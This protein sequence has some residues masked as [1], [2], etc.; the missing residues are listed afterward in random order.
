MFRSDPI[1]STGNTDQFTNGGGPTFLDN[2][3]FGSGDAFTNAAA[4]GTYQGQ[5]RLGHL[6]CVQRSSRASDGTP[7]HIRM[8]GPGFDNLDVP[9][10]S[11]QPKLEFMIFIPTAAF[12]RQM[13]IN[14]ASLD[15]ASEFNIPLAKD[16]IDFFLTATRRQNYLI[17][18]RTHRAFPLLELAI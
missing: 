8:D 13:R 10:G 15:L 16:G 18:P 9:D 5:H 6:T 4:V 11:N 1:P 17:P 12:F 7:I 2:V 3:N 14:Q